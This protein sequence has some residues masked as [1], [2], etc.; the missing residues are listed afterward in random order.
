MFSR[1]LAFLLLALGCVTAAAGGAYVATRQNAAPGSHHRDRLSRPGRRTP[2][3][4]SA[5]APAAPA[6]RRNRGG[7]H[8]HESGWPSPDGPRR[9]SR[10]R[11]SL[12]RAKAQENGRVA[13]ASDRD[14]AATRE[15]PALRQSGPFRQTPGRPQ[16][17]PQAPPPSAPVA[18]APVAP[19]P[20]VAA[21]NRAPAGSPARA[22]VR[23]VDPPGV[24]GHRPA[25]RVA[26]C[27]PSARA[28]R[29]ASR[30]ASRVT[31][32][33]RAA[34]PSRRVRACSARSRS[35]NAAARSRSAPASA[36]ASTP[37]S[38]RTAAKC[39]L[40]TEAIYRDGESPAG[41]SAKKIGVAA[42]GGAILGG[43]LGG[44]K[45]AAIGARHRRRGRHGRRHGRRSPGGRRCRG[46]EI[47]TARSPRRRPSRSSGA[48]RSVIVAGSISATGRSS[49]SPMRLED[50]RAQAHRLAD[51]IADYLE[52]PERFPVLSQVRP[53]DDQG[54]LAAERAGAGRELRRDLRRLRAGD[55]AR[56]DA[57]EPSGV[58]RLLRHHRQRARASWPS[59]CPRRSTSR[60][61]CGAPRRP[62]PSSRRSRSRGCARSSACRE[63]FDGV[64]YDTASISTLHALAAA[65]EAARA[66]G[67][68]A[69]PRRTIGSP[70]RARLLQRA[71]AL[72]GRQG[73]H[74]ARTR[75]TTRCAHPGGRRVPDAH[76]RCC[77]RAIAEDRAAGLLPIAVVATVGTTSTTSVDPVRD[78]AAIC[79]PEQIWLH[80]DAAYAGV[81][82]MVPGLR[83][84]PATA[85]TPPTRSSST[86]TS[87]CSRRSISASSTAAAWTC[88]GRRSR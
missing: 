49:R 66:A 69:G 22:A 15:P 65:R 82:A 19:V 23:R 5:T 74:P 77:A 38:W 33:P 70:G 34:S 57:L 2:A 47:V 52:H 26:R 55:P 4:G 36:S 11:A 17:Q 46:G 35:W 76:R 30:R 9:P 27:H 88:C 10:P 79:G 73:G 72:L 48:S 3:T 63:A 39:P 43:I 81:A 18:P 83:M 42:V 29:I 64:I 78:I 21:S 25:A 62:P 14:V 58:L 85:P 61:C 1:P 31:C 40:Q 56:A 87:G 84:D 37:W 71:R 53:G 6:G 20:E 24:V 41:D 32:S 13:E 86:R 50:F 7:R 16:S 45:G 51:W 59:S 28:W 75:A 8:Q 12:P 44:K 54:R 80:V 67:A 60:R 68:G